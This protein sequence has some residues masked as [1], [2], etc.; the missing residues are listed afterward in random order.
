MQ[1]VFSPSSQKQMTIQKRMQ[2][3]NMVLMNVCNLYMNLYV[4]CCVVIRTKKFVSIRCI[5]LLKFVSSE[6]I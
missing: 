2:S 4:K 1:R 5:Q 6:P 3:K